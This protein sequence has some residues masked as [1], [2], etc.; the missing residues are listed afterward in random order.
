M[1]SVALTVH[2]RHHRHPQ[3]PPDA[4]GAHRR[5]S[6]L[7][8]LDRALAAGRRRRP[9]RPP[10]IDA[11]TR[12]CAA[13]PGC[14]PSSPTGSSSAGRSSARLDQLD[15]FADRASTPRSATASSTPTSSSVAQR[16]VDRAARRAVGGPP[17]PAAHGRAPWPSS[18]GATPGRPRSPAT[19]RS[20]RRSRRIDRLEVRGRDS[21]GIHVFVWDH[22]L[23][24]PTTRRAS[25]RCRHA[26]P[27]RCSSPARCASPATCLSLRLQGGGRDRRAR[28]QHR[29]RCAPRSRPTTCC[30]WRSAARRPAVAVLG[31]TR[32]ASVGIISEPNAHPVNSEE[33]ELTG[34]DG[35]A[36]RRRRAQRRRRQPRRPQG[37]PRPAHPRPDHHRRQGD[38][39]AGGPPRSPPATTWSSRSGARCGV[40]GLRGD[41]RRQRDRRPT[42]C[43]S[44][45]RQRAGRC[46]SAS[47]RIASSSPAS[48]TA[49]SRRRCATCASTA[50]T[51]GP[52]RRVLD[53]DGAGELER[54]AA[55]RLRRRPSCRSPPPTSS[56]AEVTT[57]DIDRG[58]AP[59]FLLKEITESPES[60]A[61]DAARQD[62]R[63]RRAAARRR[64]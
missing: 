48:R 38:P 39:G 10:P 7:E 2:V 63:A 27:T 54:H 44:P 52:G 35:R 26:R 56:T 53:A 31:H 16:R 49:W 43:C 29:G 57:R 24:S 25:P 15:A 6:S 61:Q 34:G 20:S 30:A 58:D 45:S 42:G 46:T 11:S 17:R 8:R 36:V 22:G 40:R 33:L 14:W 59:H 37:R 62:R 4:A 64:R 5:P 41:R 50:S 12:C 19:C 21:A 51:V 1:P 3:P 60:F 32:W 55:A 23:D 18:P 28:R 9:S 47:P 13:C